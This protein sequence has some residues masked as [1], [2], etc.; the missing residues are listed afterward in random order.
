MITDYE[1]GQM[2]GKAD[3]IDDL[4][5]VLRMNIKDYK[6]PTDVLDAIL[7]MAKTQ[8]E[9]MLKSLEKEDE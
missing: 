4:L 5:I 8:R 7:L 9:E 6:T 3:F 2:K 1:L